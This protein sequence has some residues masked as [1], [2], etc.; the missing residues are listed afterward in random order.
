MKKNKE[1]YE[2]LDKRTKEYKD[3]KKRMQKDVGLGDAVEA[4]T[5]L[6]GIKKVVEA[7]TDDCGCDERKEKWN[8]IKLFSI[9]KPNC[10]EEDEFN[11]LKSIL[12]TNTN[13]LSVGTNQ[14]LTD[15]YN[16]VFNT[17][18][19]RSNC[20]S[21]IRGMVKELKQYIDNY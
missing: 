17:R 15:Y 16:K 5:K 14:K 4:I 6:T 12:D 7:I 19:T 21:C 8:K 13:K 10:L 3:Y 11:D 2:S 20:S 9:K 1:Y 18:K